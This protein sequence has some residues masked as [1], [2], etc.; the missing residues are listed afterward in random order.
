MKKFLAELIST[1]ALVLCGTG[2]IV[3]DEQTGGSVGHLRICLALGLIVF[4]MIRVF[5][6]VSGAHMNP[7][8]SMGLASIGRFPWTLIPSYFLAQ[9]SG[10]MAASL[11]L[12]QLF[13][14]NVHLGGTFPAGSDLQSFLLEF[15]L[16]FVLMYVIMYVSSGKPQ[17]PAFAGAVIGGV[18]F[19]EALIAGPICGASMNPFRSLAP[20]LVSGELDSVWIYLVAPVI[21]AISG[22]LVWN[23]V[24]KLP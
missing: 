18:L 4:A 8:I 12:D 5:G 23:R 7:A 17:G 14:A 16:T 9:F 6:P 11:L 22:A 3:L 13:P 21:G 2:V 15:G 19:V 10:A 1:F 24:A 20:A